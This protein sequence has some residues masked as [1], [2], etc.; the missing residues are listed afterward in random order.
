[1]ADHWQ[2]AAMIVPCAA[3]AALL[4]ALGRRIEPFVRSRSEIEGSSSATMPGPALLRYAFSFSLLAVL[5]TLTYRQ[6]EAY[7]SMDKLYRTTIE[8]NP[9]C[10]L[11]HNELGLL[12]ASQGKFDDAIQQYQA[13]LQVKPDYAESLNNLGV[14]LSQLDRTDAAIAEY[15]KAIAAKY[16][17]VEAHCN[18]GRALAKQG[19]NKEAVAQYRQGLKINADDLPIL[20]NLAWLQ[21]TCPDA[22]FRNG[23][24]AVELAERA[25]ALSKG[26][27][28]TVLDTLAAAY[29][30]T[31]RFPAAIETARRAYDLAMQQGNA[32]RAA[33]VNARLRLYQLGVPYRQPSTAKPR[34]TP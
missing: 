22:T 32:A 16:E 25:R 33:S 30:E 26:R 34:A 12:L 18:L 11:M 24:E 7:A 2:Y 23:I 21:A 15:E 28:P 9:D 4:A 1:V 17:Y 14:A 29:A 6:S 31:K 13:A 5:A 3:I 19:R 20:N 10:W 27:E 8:R